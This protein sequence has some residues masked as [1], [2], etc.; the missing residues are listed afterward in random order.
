VGDQSDYIQLS[1][2]RLE[3]REHIHDNMFGTKCPKVQV[4]K[5][6]FIYSCIFAYIIDPNKRYEAMKNE[7][8]YIKEIDYKSW[9]RRYSN[10]IARNG[11]SSKK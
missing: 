10:V 6:S 2:Q 5:F 7:P 11:I 4:L 9:T 1:K 8:I 3:E